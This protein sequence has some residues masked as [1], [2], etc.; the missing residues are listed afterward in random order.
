MEHIGPT[1]KAIMAQLDSVW[2]LP[3]DQNEADMRDLRDPG[4]DD[5]EGPV[6]HTRPLL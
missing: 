3:R 4:D 1:V 2:E 6:R 5:G